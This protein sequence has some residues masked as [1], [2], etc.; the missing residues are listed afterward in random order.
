MTQPEARRPPYDDPLAQ[1]IGEA[2]TSLGD[3]EYITTFDEDETFDRVVTVLVERLRSHLSTKMTTYKRADGETIG[4]FGWVAELDYL[5]DESETVE[6]I[7][8]VWVRE[9]VSQFMYP[10]PRCLECYAEDK[11]LSETDD[12]LL[13]AECAAAYAD[14]GS[15]HQDA[16]AATNPI[17][18][19][20]GLNATPTTGGD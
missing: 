16:L 20:T 7:G 18:G 5:D 17:S 13:C 4:D 11:P 19:D 1:V 6:I 9:S 14:A 15:A 2:L 3:G 10:P 12:G 8:E